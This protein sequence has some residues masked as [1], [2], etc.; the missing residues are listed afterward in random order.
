[1]AMRPSLAPIFLIALLAAACTGAEATAPATTVAPIEPLAPVTTPPT[2]APAPTTTS[3]A[4]TTTTTTLPPTVDLELE[5]VTT[6]T[7]D[8][9]PK[10]VVA[11]GAGLF[12]AQNMMYRHTITVYND[13]YELV[14]TI[15]DAVNLG[16]FGHGEYA[17][18]HRGAPVEAVGTTDGEYMYVSNYQMYGEGYS[19]AGGDGCNLADWDESFVYRIA[20]DTL[21]IDQVIGVGAVPKFLAITP[22]DTLVLAS[23][24]CSFD[25]SVI[26]TAAGE[27]I[28]RVPLGR[29]PRGI[30][31]TGD[32]K[33]AYVAIMGSRDIA[34]VDLESFGVDWMRNVGANPRHLILDPTDHHL[35]ATLNGE[36]TVAV[37][38]LATG[39]VTNRITSGAAPRSMTISDDGRSLYVVNYNSGTMS[40]IDTITF[41]V[42][43]TL[44]VPEHPIG[45]TFDAT[46]REVWV[47]SYSGAIT[48]FR[49][50]E[51]ATP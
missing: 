30:A 16:E 1:M 50:T 35:Y 27:E 19:R 7:G 39:T 48:V 28:A 37:I 32:G 49:E 47:A 51:P 42:M 2:T 3:A 11:T 24:W 26:D 17:D 15:P 8:I 44:S 45:I 29:H 20:T 46:N 31:V 33:T 23:N 12:F 9:S 40:K 6:I 36:G 41:E 13:D 43:Q 34:I 22:D 38:D 4:P 18:E 5:K 21:E 10:S 14:A 25:L